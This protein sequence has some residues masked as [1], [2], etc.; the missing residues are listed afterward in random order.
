VIVV[1]FLL[2]FCPRENIFIT[3][4]PATWKMINLKFHHTLNKLYQLRQLVGLQ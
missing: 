3:L 2:F 1:V 4:L